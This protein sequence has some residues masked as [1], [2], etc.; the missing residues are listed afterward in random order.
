MFESLFKLRGP[1]SNQQK[2][3]LTIIGIALLLGLW[4][5]LAYSKSTVQPIYERANQEL[6]ALNLPEHVRDSMIQADERADSIA[7][8]NATEFERVFPV[9]PPPQGVFASYPDL[10]QKDDLVINSFKSVWL[11]IKGYIWALI[12]ALPIGFLIGL[13][14]L[15]KGM[16][17]R[18]VEALR[19]LPLTALTGVFMAWFGTSDRM[20]IAFLAFGILVYLLPVVVQRINEVK[21]VYLKT[22]FTIG[23]NTWQ[24]IRTVYIPSVMSRVWDDIR[25]LTAIS[26]TYIIV[27]EL[28]NS[29]EGGVGAMIFKKSR[30]GDMEKVFAILLV[31]I[32]IGLLQDRYF[33]YLD[34]KLFPFKHNAENKEKEN[35]F[36]N[37][38]GFVATILSG[39]Y[40]LCAIIPVG[41]QIITQYIGDGYYVFFLLAVVHLA[42]EG[43]AL[44]KQNRDKPIVKVEVAA[45]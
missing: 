39:I 16:F 35:L 12:I 5:W 13:L 34:K 31:I 24:T 25:V 30:F 43:W 19:Y 28:V 36:Q 22:V 40:I 32:F 18:P 26:W 15:F 29:T 33:A 7:I 37:L 23:A 9:V 20:K 8:A 21:D 3:I 44:Y 1:L 17:N 42:L 2:W 11:N 6:P 10:L 45:E 14:P 27:A 38:V 41:K 4:T